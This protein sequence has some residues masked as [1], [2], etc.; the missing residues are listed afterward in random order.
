[1]SSNLPLSIANSLIDQDFIT[2]SAFLSIRTQRT[3]YDK[4]DISAQQLFQ[5]LIHT[6]MSKQRKRAMIEIGHK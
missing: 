4:V 6:T 2:L 3:F 5:V 1:M